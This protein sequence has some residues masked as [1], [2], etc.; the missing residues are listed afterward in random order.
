VAISYVGAATSQNG[1]AVSLASLSGGI[2][3]PVLEGDFVLVG[4]SMASTANQA[5]LVTQAGFTNLT[6]L[7]GDDSVDINLVVA[8]K[9]M[10]STPDTS[11][12]VNTVGTISADAHNTVAL[13]FRGV[14][15][16]T[17]FDVTHTT[18]VGANT[19]VPNPAAI[20][21]VT[22]GAQIVLI[23]AG[24]FTGFAAGSTYTA[25]PSGYGDLVQA[26]LTSTSRDGMIGAA[27][28]AW[29]G[30]GADDPGTFATLNA[31]ASSSWAAYTIALRP[32]PDGPAVEIGNRNSAML[33][34]A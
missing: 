5:P 32:A 27:R 21:P 11:V 12:T 14:D 22:A 23:V 31:S 3:G 13:V 20:T 4:H 7:F 24:A 1:N 34:A 17:P 18:A 15:P 9:R 2:G 28:K 25:A 16:T 8:H 33:M 29:S 26:I 10:G 6:D 30:S 19:G